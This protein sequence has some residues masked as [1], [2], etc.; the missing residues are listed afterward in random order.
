MADKIKTIARDENYDLFVDSH[1]NIALVYGKDAYAQ[2]VNAK[3]RTI[4]GE[5]PLDVN[6]GLPYFQ[7]IFKDANLLNVFES[8]VIKMLQS[9]DFVTEVKSFDCNVEDGVLYYTA[10]IITDNGEMNVNG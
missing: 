5:M 9:L 1:K 6:G 7:T 8:E 10:E 4:L 2:I 3:M